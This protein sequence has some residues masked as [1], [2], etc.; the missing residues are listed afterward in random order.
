MSNRCIVHNCTNTSDRGKMIGDLC[1]SCH[2]FITTGE[3]RHS[4]AYRNCTTL[5]PNDSGTMLRQIWEHFS[6]LEARV[7]VLEEI[8]TMGINDEKV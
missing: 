5:V 8:I 2:Q 4:Q 6:A 7:S 1:S 3:G